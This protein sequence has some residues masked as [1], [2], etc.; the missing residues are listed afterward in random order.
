MEQNRIY[1]LPERE[2]FTGFALENYK[3]EA[4]LGISFRT[5]CALG[6]ADFFATIGERYHKP[7]TDVIDSYRQ[8]PVWQFK[9]CD[10]FYDH[11]PLACDVVALEL[12]PRSVPLHE[13]E[14][15]KRCIVV[16]GS[17]GDGL[18][19][20][21]LQKARYVVSLPSIGVSIN[22][23]SAMAIVA[24]QRWNWLRQKGFAK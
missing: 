16:A 9:N 13:F 19:K 12:S 21:I 1:R 17:E 11:I 3:C 24:Y 18:S 7:G 22:V 20:D 5:A 23:S 6:V 4:N 2:F 10:D 8:L 14:W 15:P